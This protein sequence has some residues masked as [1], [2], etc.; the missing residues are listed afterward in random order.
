MSPRRCGER[1]PDKPLRKPKR[2]P[3]P[4]R[5]GKRR[6]PLREQ[7]AHGLRRRCQAQRPR[8]RLHR[9]PFRQNRSC[10]LRRLRAPLRRSRRLPSLLLRAPRRRQANRR[11]PSH[12]CRPP[13]LRLR[14]RPQRSRPRRLPPHQLRVR[15]LPHRRQPADQRPASQFV[16]QRLQRRSP[17][18][19]RASRG[20]PPRARLSPPNPAL[21]A[22]RRQHRARLEGLTQPARD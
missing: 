14:P 15:Q 18:V 20:K 19:L 3:G 6:K 21:S 9:N 17:R 13:L 12:L 8:P 1:S 11:Q 10:L 4:K 22:Q 2:K 7:R 5:K 16:P